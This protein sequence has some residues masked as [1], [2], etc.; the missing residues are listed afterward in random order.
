MGAA[1]G[2][3][4]PAAVCGTCFYTYAPTSPAQARDSQAW[5]W[6]WL[7]IPNSSF[8]ARLHLIAHSLPYQ[9]LSFQTGGADPHPHQHSHPWQRLLTNRS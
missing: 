1:L 6:L 2:H 9:F 3:G 8:I 7:V 5:L 4:L